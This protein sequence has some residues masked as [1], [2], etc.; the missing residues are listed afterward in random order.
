M[1]KSP[2]TFIV[3]VLL[4]MAVVSHVWGMTGRFFSLYGEKRALEEKISELQKKNEVLKTE[5]DYTRTGGFLEREGKARLNLKKSGEEVAVIVEDK[6][7]VRSENI[8]KSGFVKRMWVGVVS[9]FK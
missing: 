8:K 1:L 7:I 2:V 5:I 9:F 3:A 6:E 4:F